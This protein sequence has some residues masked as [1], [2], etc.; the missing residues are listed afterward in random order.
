LDDREQKV[1]EME[2]KLLA[3][4]KTQLTEE[5][6]EQQEMLDELDNKAMVGG[7]GRRKAR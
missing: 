6:R 7:N 2:A 1:F 3:K 5:E 4:F